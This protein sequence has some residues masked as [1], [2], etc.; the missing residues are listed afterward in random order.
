[1]NRRNDVRSKIRELDSI[2]DQCLR[3][4]NKENSNESQKSRNFMSQEARLLSL[5]QFVSFFVMSWEKISNKS[6]NLGKFHFSRNFMSRG[7]RFRYES[8]LICEQYRY[9]LNKKFQ[10]NRRNYVLFFKEFYWIG[11]EYRNLMRQMAQFFASCVRTN[12]FLRNTVKFSR[13]L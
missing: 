10:T 13:I 2:S 1:M 11:I 7:A 3:E 4:M 8:S 5:S 12:L 9:E 6:Q